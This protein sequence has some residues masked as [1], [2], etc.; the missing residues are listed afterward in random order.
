MKVAV[1]HPGFKFAVSNKDD[2]QQEASEFGVD[3]YALD[4]AGEG[5]RGRRLLMIVSSVDA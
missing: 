4:K 2:F 1:N 5:N 3:V